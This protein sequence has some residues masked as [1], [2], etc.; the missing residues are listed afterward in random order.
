LQVATGAGT[1]TDTAPVSYQNNPGGQRDQVAS[2]FHLDKTDRS[3]SYGFDLG[4]YDR[5]RRSHVSQ[6][7]SGT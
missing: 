1:V 6:R 7:F 2:A 4:A 5:S 3:V